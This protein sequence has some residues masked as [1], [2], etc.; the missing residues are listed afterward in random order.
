MQ[1]NGL[2]SFLHDKGRNQWIMHLTF[3]PYKIFAS[4]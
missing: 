3:F 4:A 2:A 1:K